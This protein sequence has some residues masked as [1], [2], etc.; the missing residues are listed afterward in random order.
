MRNVKSWTPPTWLEVG[1][2]YKDAF[3]QLT[4]KSKGR[5]KLPNSPPPR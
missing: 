5:H 3:K 4:A 1:D 2:Q